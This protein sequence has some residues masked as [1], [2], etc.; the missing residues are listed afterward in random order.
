MTDIVKD[1]QVELQNAPGIAALVAEGLI[2]KDTGFTKGWI[3]DSNLFVRMENSQKCSIVVS[4]AGGWNAPDS[5]S[6]TYFPAV[7]VDIWADPT[8]NADNSVKVQDARA[9]A[10]RVYE[11]V[12][13]VLH[14]TRRSENGHPV[15]FNNTVIS[16][17]EI[18]G[19]PELEK[20]SDGDGAYMMRLR[21]GISHY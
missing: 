5:D 9:K 8:R 16:S 10:F 20:V 12:K 7:Y 21:V 4:Y 3:F 13:K 11:Q 19:E 6:Q 17:S 1:V 15:R 2:G 14:L 18:L